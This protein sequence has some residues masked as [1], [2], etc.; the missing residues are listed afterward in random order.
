MRTISGIET[1]GIQDNIDL[2]GAVSAATELP[3]HDQ[4]VCTLF[5]KDFH[6]GVAA[7]ANSLVRGGFRGLIWAG[8]RGELPGWTRAL[9]K[10]S[11]GL[12]NVGGATLGFEEIA[13]GKHFTQ[14]K[15]EFM[16][17]L[18]R[19]RI[20]RKY[21]WYFDPD[22]TV[23]CSWSFFEQWVEFGVALCQEITNG[24]MPSTHPIRC[25]WTAAAR[26]AGWGDPIHEQ[27]RYYN[28]GF[29]GVSRDFNGF[30]TTWQSALD[31]AYSNGVGTGVLKKGGREFAFNTPDQDALNI[32]A[33]YSDVPLSAIGP[34]G[35]GFTPGGFT[36]YHT[37][38]R[39]KPWRKNFLRY[40]L[41]GVPPSN[42][43]KHYLQNAE[44]PISPYTQGH[45]GSL[46]LQAAIATAI[47]RFY[48]K[49]A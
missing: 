45:L 12:F 43:D 38:G 36:M 26:G 23:R 3:S 8:Y 6:F 37:L 19:K 18:F 14:F 11:N 22:I 4:V 32:A 42:G 10:L 34:E 16:A 21:L 48:R 47:G 27:E 30:L 49:G 29:V 33:M 2:H 40:A 20:A 44:G 17:T 24:T 35:M 39:A 7:L 13:T 9:P 15:P 46:R 5:E 41:S 1:S 31:L 28:A 25:A